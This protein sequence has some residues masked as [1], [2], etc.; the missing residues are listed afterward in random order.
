ML[1]DEIKDSGF[2]GWTKYHGKDPDETLYASLC[3]DV[4]RPLADR[5]DP[6]G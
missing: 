1:F 2:A 5:A 3:L 6:L 4:K